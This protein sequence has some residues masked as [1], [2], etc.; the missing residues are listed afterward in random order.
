MKLVFE[1]SASGYLGDEITP[2]KQWAVIEFLYHERI[3]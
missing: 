1:L 2:Y 3:K